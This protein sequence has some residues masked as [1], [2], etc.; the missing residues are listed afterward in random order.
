MVYNRKKN[1]VKRKRW[2]FDARIGK[3][4]PILGGTGIRLGNRAVKRIVKREVMKSEETKKVVS[5]YTLSGGTHANLYT[6]Q[7]SNLSQ[8]NTGTTRVGDKVFYCGFIV[9]GFITPSTSITNSLWR[10]YIIQHRDSYTGVANAWNGSTAAG[11]SMLFR[12]GIVDPTAILNTDDVKVLCQRTINLSQKFSGEVQEKFFKMNCR[13]MKQYQ[14]RTGASTDGE[15]YNY[16]LLALPYSTTP[17]FQVTG[18]TAVGNLT[19]TAE[20]IFKDA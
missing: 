7:L 8:G 18:S 10:L 17:G 2:Y 20:Q 12:G 14:F 19:I 15:Y 5:N 4:V 3:N 6:T 9:K 16:Y 1:P 13:I 11:T